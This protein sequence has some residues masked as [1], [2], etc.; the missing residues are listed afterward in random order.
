MLSHAPWKQPEMRTERTFWV[1]EGAF[2]AM[3]R[4]CAREF[5]PLFEQPLKV[6]AVLEIL[7]EQRTMSQI[8]S[9]FGVHVNSG[10]SGDLF[11]C[12][13]SK[14]D[15]RHLSLTSIRA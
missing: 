7:K 11:T 2:L 9:E 8:A 5:C 10:Y 4:Q 6:Q 1:R 14:S 3:T 13:K 15:Y 12:S